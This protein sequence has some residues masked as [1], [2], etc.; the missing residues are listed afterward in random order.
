MNEQ[1]LKVIIEATTEPLKKGMEDAKKQV[2]GFKEEV[3][4]QQKIVNENIKRLSF[5]HYYIGSA[6]Y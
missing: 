4:K 5:S 2:K 3:E 6:N 1:T